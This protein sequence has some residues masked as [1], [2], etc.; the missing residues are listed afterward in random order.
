MDV[1]WEWGMVLGGR[2]G[3]LGRAKGEH[4]ARFEE[5]MGVYGGTPTNVSSST[6]NAFCLKH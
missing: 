4:R 2:D 3:F 5:C 1:G 6:I